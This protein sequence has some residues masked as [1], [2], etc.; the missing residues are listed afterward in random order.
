MMEKLV[1]ENDALTDHLNRQALELTKLRA[2][3]T[4]AAQFA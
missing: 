1:G 2:A 4:A 3:M